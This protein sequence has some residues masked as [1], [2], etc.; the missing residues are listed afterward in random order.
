V[1]EWIRRRNGK[2]LK[3]DKSLKNA[4]RTHR[5]LHAVLGGVL[6]RQTPSLNKAS[7][8]ELTKLLHV[9]LL[10]STDKCPDLI[11]H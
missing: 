8:T 10:F 5:Q 7:T 6:E 3:P 1:G 11:K 2:G 9:P 4:A